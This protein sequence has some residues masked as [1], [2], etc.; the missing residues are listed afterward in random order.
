MD[1]ELIGHPANVCCELLF[2][3]YVFCFVCHNCEERCVMNVIQYTPDNAVTRR[4]HSV[5]ISG[6]MYLFGSSHVLTHFTAKY[7]LCECTRRTLR[8]R[9]GLCLGSFYFWYF[10]TI[11]LKVEKGKICQPRVESCGA[12]AICPRLLCSRL[13]YKFS[14]TFIALIIPD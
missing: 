13:Q 3:V 9:V 6:G 2:T 14:F 1:I 4:M 8:S 11:V 10:A 7:Q 5:T 12:V